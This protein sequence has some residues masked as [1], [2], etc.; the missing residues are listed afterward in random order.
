[1]VS[2]YHFVNYKNAKHSQLRD[3][4]EQEKGDTLRTN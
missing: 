4:S 3:R 2:Y 1:M